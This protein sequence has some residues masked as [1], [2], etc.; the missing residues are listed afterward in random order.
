MLEA[1]KSKKLSQYFQN[2]QL[3]TPKDSIEGFYSEPDAATAAEEAAKGKYKVGDVVR[4]KDPNDP[5]KYISYMWTGVTF[6]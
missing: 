1:Y 5:T 6:I 4:T 3:Q 2:Q